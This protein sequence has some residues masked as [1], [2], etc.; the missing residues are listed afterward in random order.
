M[1]GFTLTD[2][3]EVFGREYASLRLQYR[4]AIS[5]IINENNREWGEKYALS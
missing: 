2:I 4:N 1:K 3:S 5:R